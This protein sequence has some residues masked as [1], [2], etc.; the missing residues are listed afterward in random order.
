MSDAEDQKMPAIAQAAVLA[1][2][3][4]SEE[5]RKRSPSASAGVEKVLAEDDESEEDRKMSPSG[6]T[7]TA[8]DIFDQDDIN[9]ASLLYMSSQ[10]LASPNKPV[11]PATKKPVKPATIKKRVYRHRL[12][13]EAAEIKSCLST[14]LSSVINDNFGPFAINF[15]IHN[16]VA[17]STTSMYCRKYVELKKAVGKDITISRYYKTV[18]HGGK[19]EPS[20]KPIPTSIWSIEFEFKSPVDKKISINS[21][22]FV[23][24]KSNLENA[25]LGLFADRKFLKNELMGL[26]MGQFLSKTDVNTG[27][28]SQYSIKSAS[29]DKFVDAKRGFISLD[30]TPYYGMGVHMINDPLYRDPNSSEEPTSKEKAQNGKLINSFL[31]PELLLYANRVINPGEEIYCSYNLFDPSE[32]SSKR[33]RHSRV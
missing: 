6:F 29:L 13:E 18:I 30:S 16:Y 32:P 27:K 12:K 22:W 8:E 14:T 28:V 20:P 25:G 4:E 1:E 31:N 2:D 17:C 21:P 9:A 24:K 19:K 10:S 15:D 7:N 3:G 23:V 26:Y 11:K 33:A 5:D